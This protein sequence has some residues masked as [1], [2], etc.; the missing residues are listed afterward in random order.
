MVQRFKSSRVQGS[1]IWRSSTND[2]VSRGSSGEGYR[3]SVIGYR[4]RRGESGDSQRVSRGKSGE[5]Y[6]LSVI[7]RGEARAVIRSVCPA[8]KA[9]KV[10]GCRLSVVGRGEAKAVIRSVCPAGAAGHA[11][12]FAGRREKYEAHRTNRT[13]KIYRTCVIKRRKQTCGVTQDGVYRSHKS[14][15]SY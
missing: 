14:Y 13:Y 9:G 3:L 11:D 6:R 1:R 4:S 7:G 2:R 10:I 12:A 8:G 5:G 15:R